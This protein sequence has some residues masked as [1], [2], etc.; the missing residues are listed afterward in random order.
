MGWGVSVWTGGR[1][2]SEPAREI[3]FPP[4][5]VVGFCENRAQVATLA[6][7]GIARYVEP[8]GN[9]NQQMST[10][11]TISWIF[12]SYSLVQ[13]KYFWSIFVSFINGSMMYSTLFH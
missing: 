4:C 12:A 9:Y 2:Q 7:G 10:I 1:V 8:N 13:I 11:I 6:M 3:F 5:V